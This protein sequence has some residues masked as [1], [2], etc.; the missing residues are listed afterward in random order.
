MAGSTSA[1][2]PTPPSCGRRTEET[3]LSCELGR[4]IWIGSA[5]RHPRH[6]QPGPARRLRAALRADR[7]RRLGA[8]RRSR[9]AGRRGRGLHRRRPL[10]PGGRCGGGGRSR[11]CRWCARRWRGTARLAGSGSQRTH[12]SPRRR[13]P[14]D[15]QLGPRTAPGRLEPAWRRGRPRR[16]SGCDGCS[17]GRGGEWPDR[18]SRRA[19]RSAR[20]ALHR[21][22]TARSRGG[23]PRGAPGV[24]GHGGGRRTTGPRPG[25]HHRRS[26]LQIGCPTSR[27]GRCRSRVWSPLPWGWA[28]P[29]GLA[30][31]PRI[32]VHVRRTRSEVRRRAR[33][34]RSAT[35]S[36]ST[37]SAAS[38]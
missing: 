1:N 26:C 24:R 17:R 38:L 13:R 23:L 8:R 31:E 5:H 2:T 7:V 12:W 14:A 30:H 25:G 21:H 16:A 6:R 19:P 22:R 4:P 15:P 11:P 32:G 33:P 10:A 28:R 29:L 18:D 20:R 36:P 9:A 35:T 34:T 27:P 37:T 3:G